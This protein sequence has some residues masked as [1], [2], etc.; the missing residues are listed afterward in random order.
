M[1]TLNRKKIGIVTSLTLLSL[2]TQIPALAGTQAGMPGTT[3]TTVQASNPASQSKTMTPNPTSVT[4]VG[5]LQSEAGCPG[6]WDP[7]C[8]VTHLTYDANDDVWQG[9]WTL[10]AGSYNYKAA[11]NDSWNENYGLHG[12][13]GGD[14]IP[15][16]LAT[17][18]TVKFYY[19]HKSHWVTEN[20][21]SII[22]T[23]P[24]SF[25]SAIGCPGDWQPDCLRSWLQDVQ[26]TGTYGFDT[27]AIPAGS[28]EAK[29]TINESWDENYGQGGVPNGPEHPIYRALHGRAGKLPL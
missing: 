16:T 7:A 2:L 4:I 13:P 20:Q 5:D 6:D 23:V 9:S 28:Y 3:G 1:F 25:Q 14:N 21:G 15:L 19:D 27:T 12:V 29:V 24:G 22:A 10:P 26:G 11:L 8:A 17:S 18:T